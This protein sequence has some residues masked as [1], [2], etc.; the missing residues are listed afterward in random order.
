MNTFSE[1][2]LLSAEKW[3]FYTKKATISDNKRQTINAS[4]VTHYHTIDHNENSLDL[5]HVH[6]LIFIPMGQSLVTLS[7][8]VFFKVPAKIDLRHGLPS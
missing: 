4:F 6:Y 7:I 2:T 1:I 5:I 3:P 8:C